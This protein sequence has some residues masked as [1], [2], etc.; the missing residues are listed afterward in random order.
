M[1]V[2]AE[3]IASKDRLKDALYIVE[4]SARTVW[5][6]EFESSF[7]VVIEKMYLVP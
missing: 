3:A 7:K 1:D 5:I 4:S 6:S 2:A